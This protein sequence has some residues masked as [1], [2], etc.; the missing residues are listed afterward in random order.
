MHSCLSVVQAPTVHDSLSSTTPAQYSVLHVRVRLRT[1]P[2]PQSGAHDPH[3]DQ[4]A[5]VGTV[6]AEYVESEAA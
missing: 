3:A 1:E 2:G 4:S 5:N 6:V